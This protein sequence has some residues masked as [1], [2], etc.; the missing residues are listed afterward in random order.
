LISPVDLP[1]RHA[2]GEK[3]RCEQRRPDWHGELDC[4]HLA[5]RDQRQREEPAELRNIVHQIAPDVLRQ[6][7]RPEHFEA[8]G[9]IDERRKQ[10]ES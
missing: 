9:P 7:R 4:H 8:A 5:D 2:L 6:A 10:Q 3:A 1:R